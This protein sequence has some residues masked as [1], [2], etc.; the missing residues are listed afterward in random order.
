[1][2]ETSFSLVRWGK[3]LGG[4]RKDSLFILTQS[5][6][7]PVHHVTITREREPLQTFKQLDE[8]GAIRAGLQ[9]ET[10]N[11]NISSRVKIKG[12]IYL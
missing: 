8:D 2:T 12:W 1:M 3:G 9:G 4:C 7:A 6:V 5:C 11:P 10:L